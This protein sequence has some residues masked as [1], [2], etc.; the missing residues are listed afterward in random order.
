[1]VDTP[2]SSDHSSEMPTIRHLIRAE[3]DSGKSVRELAEASGGRVKFQTFQE[4]SSKPPKQF[5]KDPKT[6]TG[7]A[8]ALHVPE[9]TIVLAYAKSL[10]IHVS[11]AESAFS[12]RLPADVD[13]LSPAMQNAIL[14]VAR[15]ATAETATSRRAPTDPHTGVGASGAAGSSPCGQ[16]DAE[17]GGSLV[18]LNPRPAGDAEAA[19]NQVGD[20]AQRRGEKAAQDDA[21]EDALHDAITA[22]SAGRE[23]EQDTAARS[24]DPEAG[25]GR[26]EQGEAPDGGA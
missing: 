9:T 10:G 20:L 17:S 21:E 3:L 5:P 4:L 25:K 26:S 16:A 7:M 15:A 23:R 14:S 8:L 13:K 22:H 11:S 2:A 12:L 19:S 18:Q 24:T 6:I 1:M